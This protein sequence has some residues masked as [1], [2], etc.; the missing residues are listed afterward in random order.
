MG[1]QEWRDLHVGLLDAEQPRFNIPPKRS[2]C[3]EA[4]ECVCN[5]EGR[6]IA[7]FS[8]RLQQ[9]CLNFKKA[10]GKKVFDR[11]GKEARLVLRWR[12]EDDPQGTS[13]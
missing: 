2:L 13:K 7:Y 11:L 3:F 4:E 6:T 5:G 12:W 1:T 8:G 10:I 9:S